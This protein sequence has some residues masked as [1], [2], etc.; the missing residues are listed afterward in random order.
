MPTEKRQVTVGPS[1]R[2]VRSAAGKVLHVPKSWTL[3]PPG[4]AGLTRRVKA[5]GPH[6]VVKEKKG[7]RTYSK[8]VWAHG[9]TIA[10]EKR[11]L[12]A[13]RST[14]AYAKKQA[15]AAKRRAKKQTEYV[16]EFRESIVSFLNFDDR[17][18]TLAADLADAISAHATP[19]GS[20]TVARTTRIPIQRRAESAVIAWMRHQ[21]TAYDSMVIPRKKGTRREVRRMLAGVSRELLN[22]YR[23]GDHVAPK[24]CLLRKALKSPA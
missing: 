14:D 24:K 11:K 21:T 6:W 8:G 12:D 20:G 4:D 3:L 1:K 17:Y 13:E 2:T 5:R 18:E 9:K 16:N 15:S 23:K 22:I 7:R 10:E 19:I